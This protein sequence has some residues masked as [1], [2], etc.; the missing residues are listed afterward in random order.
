[1][2]SFAT[3]AAVDAFATKAMT[4]AA[5]AGRP[6]VVAIDGGSGAGKSTIA[7]AIRLRTAAALITLDDFYDARIPDHAW[8]T[9]PV[10][11]RLGE[12]FDWRRVRERAIEPLLAGRPGRW[13]A[14]DFA[15]GLRADGT[16]G[17]QDA[18]TE[19]APAPLVLLEGAYSASPP[20][21]DVVDVSVL[22]DVPVDERHRRTDARDDAAFLRGWHETWDD[23]ERF[24]FEAVRPRQTFDY[25]L[26]ND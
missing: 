5:A 21:A 25:V 7:N 3:I 1:M 16:Y 17:L 23:V 12:V 18:F 4:I 19:I 9:M 13:R 15:S 24:Y 14:F 22:I 2:T 10:S 26:R 8:A 20:L 6:I 11:R